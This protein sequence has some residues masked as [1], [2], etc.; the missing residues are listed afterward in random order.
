MRMQQEEKMTLEMSEYGKR[1]LMIYAE[2]F[3]EL[4]RTMDDGFTV[5]GEED[6]DTVLRA[7]GG[8]ESQQLLC[9]N[10]NEI[11]HIM[12]KMSS[13]VFLVKPVEAKMRRI[14]VNGL[15][16]E[17]IVVTDV[18][19]IERP[20]EPTTIGV[21]MYSKREQGCSSE[22]VADM[23]SVLLNRRM[24][25]SVVSPYLIDGENKSFVFVEEA[26][27]VVLTG[28]ARAVKEGET[29]SGDNYS[30]IESERGRLTVLLSDGMGS[31]EK[32]CAD[33]EWVLDLMEKLIDAGYTLEG[34]LKLVNNALL[35]R[36]DKENMSTIDICDLDL[37]KGTGVFYK[38]GGAA[39]FIKRDCSV[40]QVENPC[41]PM[42]IFPLEVPV[43]M[44]KV[45][46]D[47]EY[48]IMM[49][50]GVLDALR[51]NRYEET[52]RQIIESVKEQN[53]KEIAK[54]ILQFVLHLSCGH[55]QDDMT[56]IVLGM[57]KN[58]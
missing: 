50:D 32:A 53:P 49:T 43:A 31:G 25:V 13:E 38:I 28:V 33:S 58:T 42:G 55:I 20:G 21:S 44:E 30:I 7:K 14:V 39:S 35:S 15:K 24:E 37:H 23:L 8:W 56:I 1:R 40:E 27:F 46:Q 4:A 6:R 51:K 41:L 34:A 57:W 10:L 11:A 17:G 19:Y 18:Y 54:R 45:F 48:V 52:M 2:S 36:P 47:G 5:S 12:E 29:V 22:H 9:G 16:A 26:A 3:R